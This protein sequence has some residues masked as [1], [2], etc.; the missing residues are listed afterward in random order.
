MSEKHCPTVSLLGSCPRR[1]MASS[2]LPRTWSMKIPPCP[3]MYS[4][5]SSSSLPDPSS[6]MRVSCLGTCLWTKLLNRQLQ[7]W[8][9]RVRKKGIK[10]N[11]HN[12][13]RKS[14]NSLAKLSKEGARSLGSA[15][16]EG[17]WR[18]PRSCSPYPP[19]GWFWKILNS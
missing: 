2:F 9:S 10:G 4:Q 7:N 8:L 19:T 1:P 11:L 18:N 17:T 14:L 3:L 13:L 6:T 16:C 15:R 5:F 12:H